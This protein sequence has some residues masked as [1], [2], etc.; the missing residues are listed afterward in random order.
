MLYIKGIRIF[1]SGGLC[2]CATSFEESRI[3]LD[4]DFLFPLY[5][6]AVV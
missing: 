1:Q 2:H 6:V 5:G 3:P 4:W